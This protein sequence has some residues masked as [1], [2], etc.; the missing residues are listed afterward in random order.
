MNAETAT[1][2][3]PLRALAL[4]AMGEPRVPSDWHRE[5]PAVL[6]HDAEFICCNL[7]VDCS[8]AV[9]LTR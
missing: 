1:D 8:C 3:T 4:T 9:T 5:S 7:D 6:E 2:E